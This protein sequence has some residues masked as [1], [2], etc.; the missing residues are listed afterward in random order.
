MPSPS[1][2]APPRKPAAHAEGALVSGILGGRFPAGSVLP[3][4]RE[5]ALMLGVTR[6]TLREALQRLDRD[7]W[8]EVRHGKSTRVQDVWREGGLNVLAALVRNGGPFPKD[9]VTHLLEVRLAL[10]PAYARAAVARA[11]AQVK[12]ALNR[13]RRPA[14]DADAF[15][16][17]DW[18]LHA[19][20]ATASGNPVFT[21]ILNGFADF[22]AD[23]ARLYFTLPDAMRAST[24]F[25]D[26]LGRAAARRRPAAA[27]KAVRDAMAK[28]VELWAETERRLS[29][30]TR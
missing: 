15:A 10:A 27:E 20:L 5:L 1:A 6:P 17:F 8:I 26:A 30:E 2:A 25:Y 9:F 14:R 11:P 13:E 7:G 19:L 12:E 23:M 21:L 18:K 28:S 24:R 29:G 16:D 4:E 22:Y 3:P